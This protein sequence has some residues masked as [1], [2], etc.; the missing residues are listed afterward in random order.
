M[1]MGPHGLKNPS[2]SYYQG[3]GACASIVRPQT[4]LAWKKIYSA[5]ATVISPP[6]IREKT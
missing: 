3:K 5:A 4:P 1:G 6:R 2:I